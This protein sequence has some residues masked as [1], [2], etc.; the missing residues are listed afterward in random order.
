[1][2]QFDGNTE[3]SELDYEYLL[4]SATED[5][6]KAETNIEKL[7]SSWNVVYTSK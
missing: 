6:K 2:K 4:K 5:Y 1:M 3:N 7:E